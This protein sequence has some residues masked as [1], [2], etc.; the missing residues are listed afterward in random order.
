MQDIL[1]MISVMNSCQKRV[2]LQK[3]VRLKVSFTY[4]ITIHF[5]FTKHYL[6]GAHRARTNSPLSGCPNGTRYSAESTEVNTNSL[7]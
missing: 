4:K 2:H 6:R 7:T 1:E 3:A 5:I